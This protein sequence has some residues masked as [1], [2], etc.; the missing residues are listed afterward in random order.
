MSLLYHWK[1]ENHARDLAAG[2]G[3][4]LNQGNP[5][6]HT[7]EIGESLW[8]FSRAKSG[9]YF[10]AA[11][12]VT[13]TLTRNPEGYRYGPYRV[14]GNS[15]TSRYFRAEGQP[16][17]STLIRRLGLKAGKED[18]PLGWAFQGYSAVRHISPEAHDLLTAW[19]SDLAS[20]P[21]ARIPAED[22]LEA[23]VATG[24]AQAVLNLLHAESPGLDEKRRAYLARAIPTRS[25]TLVLQLRDLYDGKCQACGWSPRAEHDMD[26]CEAHHVRWLSR[27]GTDDLSNL[28]LL[29]PNHH[30]VV[31]GL[32][33]QMDFARM[34]FV[35]TRAVLSLLVER[36]ALGG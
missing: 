13:S 8:A 30:R 21:L 34:A 9:H 36:H 17:I 5:L 14:W 6:M 31:H 27:G 11:E 18:T 7:L 35:G 16:D 28:T 33:L 4:H 32:D 22:V 19:S 23:V 1:G 26:F 25:R 2:V 3:Y 12:L 10:L 15:R 20:E 24:D 29:C